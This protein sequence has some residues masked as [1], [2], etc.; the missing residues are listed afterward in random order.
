MTFDRLYKYVTLRQMITIGYSRIKLKNTASF[1]KQHENDNPMIYK[2]GCDYN[3]QFDDYRFS[4]ECVETT[5]L[6]YKV[7]YD[8]DTQLGMLYLTILE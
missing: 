3:V 5:V 8:C 6:G 7:G 4:W 2:M 1:W